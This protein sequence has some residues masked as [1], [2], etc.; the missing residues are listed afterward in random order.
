[1][2]LCVLP[3]FTVLL[4][5]CRL[6]VLPAALGAAT[7]SLPT[8]ELARPDPFRTLIDPERILRLQAVE[9]P[10]AGDAEDATSRRSSAAVSRSATSVMLTLWAFGTAIVL[11]RLL[12]GLV[13]VWRNGRRTVASCDDTLTELTREIATRYGIR[14]RVV[15]RVAAPGALPATW[16]L[17]RSFVI[18]PVEA[19]DWPQDRLRAILL[20]ELAHVAR[21]DFL[22][23]TVARFACALHWFNPLVWLAD[24]RLRVECEHACDDLVLA[25]GLT[26][27]NYATH[28]VDVLRNAQQDRRLDVSLGVLPMGRREGLED[29]VRAILAFERYRCTPSPRRVAL[30]TLAAIGF[31]LPLGLI[32]LEARAH[33]APKL[34]RL[35]QG[36]T[37]EILGVSTHPSG[38]TTWWG[39]DGTPLAKAPCDPPA[40]VIQSPG[41]Q[42][43]EIVARITGLPAGAALAWHPT[44]CKSRGMPAPA[45]DGTLVSGLQGA[46]AEFPGDP[47][48]CT[49]VFDLGVGPWTTEHTSDGH[50]IGIE[51]EDRAFFFG[52]AHETRAGTALAIAHNIADREVRLV[53]IDREGREH[54]PTSASWGGGHHLKM[55]DVEFSLP[56]DQ[57]REYRLQSRSVGRFEIK[58][59][60]LRPRKAGP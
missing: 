7:A 32:R 39:P 27:S 25:D 37:I 12:V 46:V 14:R 2:S 45:K 50:G 22:V 38:P 8:G 11:A 44:Q 13:A 54:L 52:A 40:D 55:I 4:P 51:R 18:L 5:R 34:E 49:V 3:V 1:M 47:A 30:I 36:V 59:V 15:L 53:A 33:D 26:P 41:Q 43:R 10:T 42:V 17:W 23:Q 60:A 6:P 31:L 21:C 58:D 24:R 19:V 16:G 48:T 20:H 9:L 28:L 35:P 56:P 57:F 29:R